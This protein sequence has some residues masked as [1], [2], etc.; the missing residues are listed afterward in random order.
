MLYHGYLE[1][2]A[3]QILH[4]A[5]KGIL[6]FEGARRHFNTSS[7]QLSCGKSQSPRHSMSGKYGEQAEILEARCCADV[8]GE[9]E[10][11]GGVETSSTM[12]GKVRGSQLEGCERGLG[13]G[14]A[15]IPGSEML[16]AECQKQLLQGRHPGLVNKEQTKEG[17]RTGKIC[18]VVKILP[19]LCFAY[20]DSLSTQGPLLVLCP[21]A[22]NL[23]RTCPGGTWNPG[24]SAFAPGVN[25]R[26]GSCA[27]GIWN[28]IFADALNVR[29]TG[30]GGKN[31]GVKIGTRAQKD[32]QIQ[33]GEA[34]EPVFGG[35][36]LQERKKAMRDRQVAENAIG[37]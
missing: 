27:H 13:P 20:V 30:G 36:L 9:R 19:A 6:K 37:E 14:C 25:V 26:S 8:V 32:S 23:Q 1:A 21:P 18:S 33:L 22:H 11:K 4:S 28:A 12:S 10:E 3:L 35:K 17:Q 16:V 34:V 24:A 5:D 7:E 15:W 29:R 31:G 2:F